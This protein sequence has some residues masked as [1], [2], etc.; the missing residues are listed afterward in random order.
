MLQ[1]PTLDFHEKPGVK[2][3]VPLRIAR[4]RSDVMKSRDFIVHQD[5]DNLRLI[6]RV[7]FSACEL[8][9]VLKGQL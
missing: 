7:D 3:E 4:D 5:D 2:I 9:S 6:A 8:A 1:V